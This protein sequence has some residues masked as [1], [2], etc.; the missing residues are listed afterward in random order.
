MEGLVGRI[1]GDVLIH[2]LNLA[3][4]YIVCATVLAV[5][6]YLTTAFSF[7]S[8]QVWAPTRFAF[9]V[10][11][12]NR[13][14]DWQDARAKAKMQ[15][16]LEKRRAARP[17]VTTQLVQRQPAAQPAFQAPQSSESRTTGIERMA[18]A[19]KTSAEDEPRRIVQP[20]AHV[21]QHSVPE[22]EV[23][24]RADTGSKPKTTLPKIAA[25]GFKLP[26]SSL[27]HRAD[28][29][30][31][32]DADETKTAGAGAHRKIRR[33]RRSRPGHADQP[34]SG[35]YDLRVQARGRHQI[36]SHHQSHQNDLCL[37][38]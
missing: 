32:I 27:L 36:Q 33:V 38:L 22:V 20:E 10:A 17:T 37:A 5:A 7:A 4:A 11:L 2:Y 23:T 35:S 3:G 24:E 9:V 18:A 6:L 19:S 16:E 26:P 21:A 15:K 25:G 12:W 30:Q 29:Q 8:V 34:G 1:L 13:Y 14:K 28:G 31:T